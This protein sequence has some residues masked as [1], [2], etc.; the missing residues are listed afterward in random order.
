MHRVL[1][2]GPRLAVLTPRAFVIIIKKSG[3]P[4]AGSQRKGSILVESLVRSYRR[5]ITG[6]IVYPLSASR[7]LWSDV[8]A[9]GAGSFPGAE[10]TG[11]Y[12]RARR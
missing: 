7:A 9:S 6:P 4:L 11:G 12:R 2:A 3:M 8:S 10:I 1:H 5:A